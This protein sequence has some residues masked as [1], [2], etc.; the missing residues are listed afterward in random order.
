M[1]LAEVIK[2]ESNV[3]LPSGRISWQF[4]EMEIGESF[5]I[6]CDPKD[7]KRLRAN[8]WAAW[9]YHTESDPLNAS[10][11]FISRVVEGGFRVWRVA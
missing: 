2:I 3:P 11:R 9:R 4:N 6:E 8:A 10:K 7:L 5:F 1:G